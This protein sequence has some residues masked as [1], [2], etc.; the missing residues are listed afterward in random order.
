MID[1]NKIFHINNQTDF[2]T[3]ALQVFKFQFENAY[4]QFTPKKNEIEKEY[5]NLKN[6]YK[7]EKEI[8]KKIKRDKYITKTKAINTALPK[9]KSSQNSKVYLSKNSVCLKSKKQPTLV[10][11]PLVPQMKAHMPYLLNVLK[12]KVD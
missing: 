10:Y 11:M 8:E 4:L 3:L 9:R 6:G 7:S 1:V 2:E 5:V 12:K